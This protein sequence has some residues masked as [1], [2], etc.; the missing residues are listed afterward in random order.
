[1]SVAEAEAHQQESSDLSSALNLLERVLQ[2]LDDNQAPL[3]IGAR[4]QELI[5]SL[6]A[7]VR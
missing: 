7:L 4:T 6:A 3:E 1:M 2:I 5:D